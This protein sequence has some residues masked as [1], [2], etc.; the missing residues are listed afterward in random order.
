MLKK[1][2][3]IDF[4]WSVYIDD[5]ETFVMAL[6]QNTKNYS[7]RFIDFL[8]NRRELHGRVHAIDELD[9]CASFMR[10]SHEFR[11]CAEADDAFVFFSPHEQEYFDEL[12]YKGKLRFD[13]RPLPDEF[14]KFGI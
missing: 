11:K 6:R 10:R 14:Y 8:F 2:D 12:Y 5:L 13:E 4:P 9:I 7:T 1:D 3:D